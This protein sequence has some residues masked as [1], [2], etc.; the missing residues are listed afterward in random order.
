MDRNRFHGAALA[1]LLSLA[2]AGCGGGNGSG[3]D[4]LSGTSGGDELAMMKDRAR[5]QGTQSPAPQER[6]TADAEG[7]DC[8]LPSPNGPDVVGVTIGMRAEDA[9]KAIACS[10]RAM[11]V[12]YPGGGIEV[13]AMPDGSRPRGMIVGRAYGDKVE[14]LLAGMPGQETVAFVRR[15]VT[16]QQGQQPTMAALQQQLRGKYGE[17]TEGAG[18]GSRGSYVA[19][20]ARELFRPTTGVWG[21]C[22]PPTHGG[23][24]IYAHCGSSV[25][26][27]V[28]ANPDNRQLAIHLIVAL[29]DGGYGMRQIDTYRQS[30]RNAAQQRQNQEAEQAKGNAP[31][32]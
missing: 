13:P 4:D 22:A 14:V 20:R 11:R 21:P 18:S 29:A 32:L 8:T 30:A 19:S 2:L 5:Q 15:D 9:Y 27:H 12:A 28:D 24:V 26:V 1:A 25:A 16:F 10:N 3:N 31:N 7:I 23:M 6:G 17:L